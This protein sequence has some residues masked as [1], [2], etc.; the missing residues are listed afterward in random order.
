[1]NT[2][3][4]ETADSAYFLSTNTIYL[5]CQISTEGVGIAL[6]IRKIDGPPVSRV[7]A[8]M[9]WVV[10]MSIKTLTYMYIPTL[11]HQVLGH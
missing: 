11:I 2:T 10:N 6:P 8:R 7:N 1:M 9:R 5:A 3:L 4:W